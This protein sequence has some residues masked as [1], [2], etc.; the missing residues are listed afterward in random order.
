MPFLN[1]PTKSPTTFKPSYSVKPTGPTLAPFRSTFKVAEERVTAA[2]GT[3]P[4][5]SDQEV[6]IVAA[7][8]AVKDDLAAPVTAVTGKEDLSMEI[9]SVK[10]LSDAVS[11]VISGGVRRVA[12]MFA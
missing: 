3:A 8:S 5:A 2:K 1:A 11:A 12:A 10:T 9:N 7:A 6:A 4:L